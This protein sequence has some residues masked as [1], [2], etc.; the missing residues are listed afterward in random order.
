M[1]R[2]LTPGQSVVI[3]V[4]SSSLARPEGGLDPLAIER[5]V[6][7]VIAARQRNLRV[8]LVSSGAVAAGLPP[9][10]MTDRP[11]DVPGLQAAA[12]VGQGL[13]MQR[14]AT[15]F[16][17]EGFV[18][19]QVLLTTDVFS[20]RRQ[21]LHARDAIGRL[22]DLGVVPIVN[23]NDTVTDDE[24]RFGDNDR[25]AALVCH[26][27]DADMLLLLTDTPGIFT[28]DPKGDDTAELLGAVQHSDRILDSL[29][30]GSSAGAF[31]SG[32][33]ATKITAARMAAWSGIPTVI[34]AASED[35]VVERA[36]SGEEVGTWI[37]PRPGRL[38]ARKLWI[39]FG[40]PSRG[41]IFVDEGAVVAVQSEGRSLL[42]VGVIGSKGG[43]SKGDAVSVLA[44]DGATVAKGIVAMDDPAVQESAGQHTS[45][46]GGEVIHR[47]NLVVFE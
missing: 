21:Y 46:A 27:V 33:A 13:L 47:D 20:N 29:D 45:V 3:K 16:A 40:L 1:R 37:G 15:G 2:A 5:T 12:A 14:Y 18:V 35:L 44:P 8:V 34:A 36:L 22:L 41:E 28:A 24:L 30:Q 43:F 39:A 4:G 25:L 17:Q 32:G 19:G 31:G 7:Q 11:G 6:G 42:A 23:E 38:S 26:L 9:L 10:K